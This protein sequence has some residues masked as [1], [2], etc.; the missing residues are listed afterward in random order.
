MTMDTKSQTKTIAA[1]KFKAECLGL[2]DK[3]A[4]TGERLIITKRGKPVAQILPVEPPPSLLGSVTFKGDILSPIDVKWNA[5][6]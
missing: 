2:L 5:R 1:G 4:L 6:S 3:I